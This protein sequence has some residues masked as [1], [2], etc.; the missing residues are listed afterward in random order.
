MSCSRLAI[1]ALLWGCVG[2]APERE[3]EPE[4]G[5]PLADPVFAFCHDPSAFS[6]RDRV[7]CSLL[8]EEGRQLCPGLAA[9][10]DA[11]I[12][13]A[14]DQGCRGA[15]DRSPPPP[16]PRVPPSP[17]SQVSGGVLGLV[18]EVL[19][20]ALALLIALG[21]VGIGFAIF[22]VI[23]RYQPRAPREDAESPAPFLSDTS[24]QAPDLAPA[25]PRLDLIQQA[26][27]ALDRGDVAEA[28]L[29]AR[30]AALRDL[31]G[32]GAIRLE[33]TRTDREILRDLRRDSGR[34]PLFRVIVVGAER[35]RWGR[36]PLSAAQGLQIVNA[37]ARLAGMAVILLAILPISAWAAERDSGGLGAFMRL[38]E[39]EGA[40][41][42][43]R[44]RSVQRLD[45]RV[46]VLVV[47]VERAWLNQEQWQAVRTWV[48]GGGRLVLLGAPVEGWSELG[49]RSG[50]VHDLGEPGGVRWPRQ[51]S[52]SWSGAQ[53]VPI[54]YQGPDSFGSAEDRVM[55][56][57]LEAQ[58]GLVL[59]VADPGI[60][61]N[62]GLVH[63][64]NL[65]F[66]R[67]LV[68]LVVQDLSSPLRVE[69]LANSTAATSPNPIQGLSNVRLLP[70]VLQLLA[71]LALAVWWRGHPFGL[72]AP[73]QR[74]QGRA[75][76]DHARAL[77]AR[78]AALG[79]SRHAAG[80]QASWFLRRYGPVS[81]DAAARQAGLS[82]AESARL[83]AE[84]RSLADDPSS[85]S[86]AY[87]E[88]LLEQACQI[89]RPRTG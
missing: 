75:L 58:S 40:T 8:D 20:W 1:V 51:P 45:D 33:P 18:G 85:H 22:S 7:Y 12:E 16:P 21:V 60:V 73:D 87:A 13:A 25:R 19:R 70:L 80:A 32:K 43:V 2:S 61:R 78:Y 65:I 47:D 56:Q 35:L 69:L 68:E 71:L 31:A 57:L 28:V 72:P 27:E 39:E 83:I 50:P 23:R 41:A 11:P 81:L 66:A 55:V 89:I 36:L 4:V 77:G 30:E 79:A 54:L 29:L 63:S 5:H 64:G 9:G 46:D 62:G 76:A 88:Q 49:E 17:S 15:S 38:F 24:V 10:C 82:E 44:L 26:R 34:A 42:R 67:T 48:E 86:P 37:A 84:L 3:R 59:A 74:G 52:Q 14:P 53:G 6:S